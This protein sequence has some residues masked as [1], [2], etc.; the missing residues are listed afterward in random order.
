MRYARMPKT[1]ANAIKPT[2]ITKLQGETSFRIGA[3][4]VSGR[5]VTAGKFVAVGT[6]DVAVGAS[7]VAVGAADVAVGVSLGGDEV[8][9]SVGGAKQIGPVM[10]LES[11]VT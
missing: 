10:M 4:P 8:G 3:P 11:S 6:S 1:K 5:A 7:D 2:A 9:V